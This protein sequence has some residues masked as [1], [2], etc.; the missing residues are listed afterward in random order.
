MQKIIL[1][2]FALF[3]MTLNSSG[4]SSNPNDLADKLIA[5]FQTKDFESYKKLLL[6]TADYKE[7]LSDFFKNNHVPESEQKQF[8]EKQKIFE[9]S[10][11]LQYRK[12]FERLLNKGEKLGI[13]WKQIKKGKFI[14]KDGKPVN[15]DEKSLSGHLNFIYKD[16]TYVFFGIEAIELSSGY[17]ISSIRTV[18]KGGIEKYVNPDLLD[19]EDI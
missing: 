7:F 3:N 2:F 16:T 8:V 1:F 6:D 10:A 5:A 14:F 4:Q 17:K 18:L 12:E 11:D 19:D 9:D 15:S 13:D